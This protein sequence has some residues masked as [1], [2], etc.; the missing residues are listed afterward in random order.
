MRVL[1]MRSKHM[2]LSLPEQ[3]AMRLTLPWQAFMLTGPRGQQRGK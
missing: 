1:T 3:S 2:H